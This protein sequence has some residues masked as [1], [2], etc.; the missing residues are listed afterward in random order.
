MSFPLRPLP[1]RDPLKASE[2][3]RAL[4][5]PSSVMRRHLAKG[6]FPGAFHTLGRYDTGRGHWRIPRTVAVQV[7]RELGVWPM[8]ETP[9]VRCLRPCGWEGSSDDAR[10]GN[11]YTV[12]A[13]TVHEYRCPTCGSR[14]EMIVPAS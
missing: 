14:V 1:D 6:R 3:G 12:G 10:T 8:N 9:E 7:G 2:V 11:S 4:G 13:T 5:I